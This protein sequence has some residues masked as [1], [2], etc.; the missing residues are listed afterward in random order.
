MK[1]YSI[2]IRDSFIINEVKNSEQQKRKQWWV[3]IRWPKGIQ[4]RLSCLS[5]SEVGIALACYVLAQLASYYSEKAP[6][7]SL[8]LSR[9]MMGLSRVIILNQSVFCGCLII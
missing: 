5:D 8:K 9:V 2:T 4:Y 3:G 6:L 7:F 1:I